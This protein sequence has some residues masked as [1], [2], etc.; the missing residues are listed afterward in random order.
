[1]LEVR[2]LVVMTK[3]LIIILKSHPSYGV[4][5]PS[6]SSLVL[7]HITTVSN[8]LS[9]TNRTNVS[10]SEYIRVVIPKLSLADEPC[11]VMAK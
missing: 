8:A 3:S 11:D 10:V 6:L 4:T 9:I 7:F 1:M 5:C 2:F